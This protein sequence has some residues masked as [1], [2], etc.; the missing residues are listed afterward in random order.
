MGL[1]CLLRSALFFRLF[2]NVQRSCTACEECIKSPEVNKIRWFV[3]DLCDRDRQRRH[4][5]RHSALGS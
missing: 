1:G 5:P 2:G 3:I 4:P